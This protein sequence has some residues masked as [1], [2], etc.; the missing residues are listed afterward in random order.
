MEYH[1][2]LHDV[3]VL[4]PISPF[5]LLSMVPNYR[6]LCFKHSIDKTNCYTEDITLVYPYMWQSEANGLTAQLL[7]L[8]GVIVTYGS[9]CKDNIGIKKSPAQ[10]KN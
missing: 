3:V 4:L 2:W 1:A 6:Y 5:F 10:K 8:V 7:I 9:Y